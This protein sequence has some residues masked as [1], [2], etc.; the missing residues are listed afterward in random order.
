VPRRRVLLDR[1]LHRNNW[2][3][4]HNATTKSRLERAATKIIKVKKVPI[5]S[6]W[7]PSAEQLI[8]RIKRVLFLD[9]PCLSDAGQY[10][11]L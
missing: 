4:V 8:D 5:A 9:N 1:R 7:A 11:N 6:D 2:T 10:F 3:R